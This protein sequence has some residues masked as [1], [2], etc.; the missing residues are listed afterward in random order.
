MASLNVADVKSDVVGGA[1]ISVSVRRKV[2]PPV[3][4]RAAQLVLKDVS[5]EVAPRSFLVITGPSGCGKSTLLNIM[6]GLDRDYD[7]SV[8][9]GP[10]RDRLAF[11]F[12]TPRLLPWRT[13]YENI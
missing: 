4:D 9:L 6:A 8:D 2:F 10:A 13:V 3:G 11:I 12:Q 5:F 1:P 7:G